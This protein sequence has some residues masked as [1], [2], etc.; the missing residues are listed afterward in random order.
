MSDDKPM[1]WRSLPE[2]A[3]PRGAGPEFDSEFS[4]GDLTRKRFLELMGA[5]AGL[6]LLAACRKPLEK[7]IPYQ[8][9]PED[10]VPGEPLTFA[11]A[12][13]H[14]GVA[15]PVL[16]RSL[17]GRPVKLEGNPGHPESRGAT[18]LITQAA[19]LGLYD[20]DRSQ[21]IESASGPSTWPDL[22]AALGA[23]RAALD[24]EKGEGL[25][26]LTGS[27]SSPTLLSLLNK[28]AARWPR[29][30]RHVWEPV[31]S[32]A[33]LEG[34]ELAFGERLLPRRDLAKADVVVALD[35]DLFGAEP[36]AVR[37]TGEHAARRRGRMNRLYCVEP[38]YTITGAAAD[39]RLSMK[40]AD[41]ELFARA[42][43]SRLGIGERRERAEWSRWLAAV[44]GDLEKAGR[45]ALV[46]AGRTQPAAVH[47]LVAAINAR[48]G[49]EA[50][51]YI[52]PPTQ[53]PE[54]S[55]A[56]L[57]ALRDDLAAGRVS[58][59]LILGANPAF[60]APAELAFA[61]ALSKARFSLHQGLYKDETARLCGW[62]VPLAHP[63]ESWG[64]GRAEDGAASVQQ[65][66]I[67]PLFDGRAEIELLA[68]LLAEP[69][70][71]AHGQV[72]AYWKSRG[73]D[74]ERALK[75]GVIPGTA[76]KAKRARPR[77]DLARRLPP[78][79]EQP[80]G[81][82]AAFR[83]DARL[84]DG[85]HANNGWLQE[86]PE[87]MTRLT[88]DNAALIS[89]A[90]AERESVS[91]G[92]VVELAIGA[93]RVEAPVFVMPGTADGVVG[94]WLGFGR[95]EGGKVARGAGFDANAL[96]S[97]EE[98]WHASGLSMRKLGRRCKLASAQEHH[99]LGGRDL[100]RE[101]TLSEFEKR[102]DF[103]REPD[104]EP[105][106][107]ETLLPRP[108]PGRHQWG[109]SVDLNS[110]VGC[111]ACVAA[112][113]AENNTPIVGKD[114]V[115]R[116]REMHWLRVDRYFVGE[117]AAPRSVAE[118]VLCM[119]CED[120]PCE[121]VCPVAATSHSD[122]GLNQMVYNRC[123]GTRYC[124][125]NCPYKVRR[126]N[127]YDYHAGEGDEERLRDNPDV[128]VRSRGVMEKCTY[129]VQRISRA[130]IQSELEDRPIR[131]GE[132]TPA[133]AQACPARAFVFGD[134]KD[135]ESRVAELRA[136]PKRYSLLSE[137]NTR[138]RTT[139]LGRL[140]NPHPDLE[141]P[142]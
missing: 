128:T 110:C 4:W 80:R 63:L 71:S 51:S 114:Q 46:C 31:N 33:V 107:G 99:E 47:A 41:V 17:D 104:K 24:K 113:A 70:R 42:L 54:P 75:A 87:P 7:I 122:E 139:Y 85:R 45:A 102:P 101:A 52:R 132:I 28:L 100:V 95:R 135:P 9:Q 16:A 58:R 6:A 59:L 38:V 81:L 39:N 22:I 44:A 116:G 20:P 108:Q 138:P 142:A 77:A 5:S 91:E 67:A 68:E 57:K 3:R 73:V 34:A 72:R 130:R 18:D 76:A 105:A 49:S 50:V 8:K 124:S 115:L 29:S 10:L 86:L 127:F 60:T 55:A 74:W 14:A 30:R 120:A 126:F 121:L 43:A 112:C 90:L 83:P 137:L 32:D 134:I 117:P 141:P 96:R 82:E 84:W 27:I 66:L 123:V 119:H 64:D 13:P 56:S 61:D 62:H 37:L 65:P 98:P 19:I 89:P 26:V 140:R 53:D 131:D 25:R 118:P 36:S 94:L 88:W 21:A 12:L 79:P 92:D 97:L 35:C 106:A 103:V 23:A 40:G 133:C 2:R 93:R 15:R 48:L 78:P 136:D 11:T 69:E 109:M 125:N 129:C 111:G 1:Y